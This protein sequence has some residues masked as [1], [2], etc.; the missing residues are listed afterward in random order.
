VKILFRDI[1]LTFFKFGGKGMKK[2]ASLELLE[3]LT[4]K[5]VG[6]S[7]RQIF[8]PFMCDFMCESHPKLAKIEVFIQI[9]QIQKLNKSNT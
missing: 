1:A 3:Q 6:N 5:V 8:Y 2:S 4:R 9:M 7:G